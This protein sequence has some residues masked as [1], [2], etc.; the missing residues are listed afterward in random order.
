MSSKSTIMVF[1]II[2]STIGSL[3]PMIWGATFFDASSVI[4]TAVGGAFGIW[5]GVKFSD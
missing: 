1:M 2:G 5:L 3:I 4:L